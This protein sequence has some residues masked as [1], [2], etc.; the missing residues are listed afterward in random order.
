MDFGGISELIEKKFL[1]SDYGI[2]L[3]SRKKPY[4]FILHSYR[5][6]GY[7]LQI[8]VEVHTWTE[9]RECVVRFHNVVI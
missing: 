4:K 8:V 5:E 9:A 7:N 6:V 1:S 2:S 3:R